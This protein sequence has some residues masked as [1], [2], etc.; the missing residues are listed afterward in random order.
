SL[1][2]G[3]GRN[4]LS[5]IEVFS[6]CPT[7]FGRYALKIGDPVK[8]ATWTSEHTVDLKKAGTMTRDELEDKIVVGEY[9]DRER[10]SLVDR[11]NELFEKVK[12]S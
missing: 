2:K 11:Y 1:K 8:L 4:G 7:Q 10:P 9:A 5:Y 12:R 6:P 3:L